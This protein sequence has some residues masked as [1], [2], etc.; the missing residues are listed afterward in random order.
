MVEEIESHILKIYELLNKQGKGVYGIVLKPEIKR[1]VNC[2][3]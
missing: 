3:S 1:R 2:S